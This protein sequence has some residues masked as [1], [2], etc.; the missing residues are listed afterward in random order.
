M[1]MGEGTR[2]TPERR[3][4]AACAELSAMDG[5]YMGGFVTA[6]GPECL[7][8]VAIPLPVLS[9]D[10]IIRLSVTDDQVSLPVADI[11]DRVPFS[12]ATYADVWQQTDF[13]V[14]VDPPMQCLFCGPCTAAEACPTKAVMMGGGIMRSRCVSCG[15]C[16]QTCPNGV[17]TMNAGALHLQDDSEA[18]V[19]IVLRQSDR[20]RAEALCEHLRVQLQRGSSCYDTLILFRQTGNRYL[21]SVGGPGSFLRCKRDV[22]ESEAN[23]L[24]GGVTGYA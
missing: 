12:V 13:T 11:S 15:T 17:Y 9:A 19:P 1:V 22:F 5:D 2:S 18:T 8:S 3:N 7:T 24:Q 14:Q 6:H 4:I 20:S 16:V 23:P 21:R 10:D